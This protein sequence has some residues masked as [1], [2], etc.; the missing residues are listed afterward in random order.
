M[1][2]QRKIC[3][4]EKRA[5][6]PYFRSTIGNFG[7]RERAVAAMKQA[8]L[9]CRLSKE[10]R[11]KI[12]VGDESESI[13]NQRLLLEEFAK[14]QGFLVYDTYCDEDYSGLDSQR[15]AFH[16]MIADAKKGCF[17]VV[18]CKS[19][20]RFT[21]DMEQVEMYL[22]GLFPL[23]GIRFMSVIDHADTEI[24]G[25][26]KARQ[27]N[28]L[29]N[30]WYCEDLSENIRGVL[31]RKREEG[32]YLGAFPP[33]GYEKDKADHHKLQID[34]EAAEVVR[35]IYQWYLEG[36]GIQRIAHLLYEEGIMPPS[37]YK[38]QKYPSFSHTALQKKTRVEYG[39]WS[40]ST[41][42]KILKNPVYLG[43]VVQGKEKKIS[44]KNKK[45]VA[46]PKEDWAIVSHMHSPIIKKE[47]FLAVQQMMKAK[48]YDTKPFLKK[49]YP[50]S[51]L[52]G[53]VFCAYCGQRMYRTKGRNGV[54]YFY[55]PVFSKS[56][57]K[58]CQHNTI[59]EDIL[60]QTAREKLKQHIA[61][62]VEEKDNQKL[63]EKAVFARTDGERQRYAKQRKIAEEQ[64]CHLQ[65]A[66]AMIYVDRSK[67]KLSE[68]E[69][70]EM[71]D[72]LERERERQKTLCAIYKEKEELTHSQELPKESI[73]FCCLHRM[74]EQIT[75]KG[76]EKEICIFWQV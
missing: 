44:Y 67:G 64:L 36:M 35:Q 48:R 25:N 15:P 57:G 69:A 19:Q 4:R 72:T 50:S 11:D 66:L 40:S 10:D 33:Y 3:W 53:K 74:I 65:K 21:R 32:Q 38:K 18:L 76:E 39:L 26:K 46:V 31:K 47:D 37:L 16:R 61:A 1:D 71:R 56:K 45:T 17:Q 73:A 29:V 41:I 28:G 63:L 62:S 43:V 23:L 58:V 60:E 42:R 6:P 52:A 68:K 49:E 9:Y 5:K 75:V 27:I 30:E 13:Q 55:C 2:G 12:E 51:V 24:K 22:H 8:A 70:E 54:Y 20:S 34:E 14:E 7:G 59:R